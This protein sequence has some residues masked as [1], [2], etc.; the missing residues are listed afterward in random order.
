MKLLIRAATKN[1]VEALLPL[2]KQGFHPSWTEGAILSE[3]DNNDTIFLVT[4][5]EA[6]QIVGFAVLRLIGGE[7]ELFQITT[8][9]KHRR[10]G[11]AT[12]LLRRV[13]GDAKAAGVTKIF[14]EV[15]VSNDAAITMY[16][17]FGFTAVGLRRF[18]YIEPTEDAKVMMA[19]LW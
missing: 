14:L 12:H 18:Y 3:I 6:K 4:E 2:E 8:A 7:A 9:A 1:D 10:E 17:R 19:E 15:R 13:I 5:D 16:E 11:I